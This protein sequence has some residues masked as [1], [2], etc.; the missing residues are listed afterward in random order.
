MRTQL[1]VGVSV[2]ERE[3]A[4]VC[5]FDGSPVIVNPRIICNSLILEARESIPCTHS[6]DYAGLTST[7]GTDIFQKTF[8][9]EEKRTVKNLSFQKSW[10][11]KCKTMPISEKHKKHIST[12]HRINRFRR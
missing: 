11:K 8:H 12:L 10:L 2:S 5:V 9:T 4:I 7:P 6:Q 1:G 3:R